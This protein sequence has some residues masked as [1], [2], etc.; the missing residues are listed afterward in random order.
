[1]KRNSKSLL[2][3]FFA[4]FTTFKSFGQLY[5]QG[6]TVNSNGNGQPN[7]GISIM[8]P[9]EKLHLDGNIKLEGSTNNRSI[10]LSP[11][12]GSGTRP[13]LSILG[14]NNG[15]N[16][17]GGPVNVAGGTGNYGTGGPLNLSGGNSSNYVGGNVNILGGNGVNGS[18]NV[19]I[20]GGT[21]TGSPTTGGYVQ[22]TTSNNASVP[23][24]D[25]SIQTGYNIATGA[26]YGTTFISGS[27]GN[28]TIGNFLSTNSISMFAGSAAQYI[29][30]TGI[31]INK[32]NPSYPLD[33]TGSMR[34]SGSYITS[35]MRY[36]KNIKSISNSLDIVKKLNGKS[37]DFDRIK[38]S[39][40]GF[41]SVGS[42]GF[43]AQDV[44]KILPNLVKEDN[45]GFLSI[46]YIGLMP[47]LVEAIKEQQK[48]IQS[49]SERLEA[50]ELKLKVNSELKSNQIQS[51][52]N[53]DN[54]DNILFQN[55]PNPFEK[56]TVISYKVPVNSRNIKIIIFDMQG[57]LI[58]QIENLTG[59]TGTITI[60]GNDL[61]AGMYIYSLLANDK[62][63]ASNKMILTK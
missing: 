47:F 4:V 51:V 8:Y 11:G 31:G 13:S 17:N 37:Y 30:N 60:E 55:S 56:H 24:A 39:K 41:D 26:N 57:T 59:G 20:K 43:L 40:M 10:Y 62:E 48:T 32:S 16:G 7:V 1:M 35:D 38:F 46:N 2:I 58:K 5:T 50:L 9:D 28:T 27:G 25:I 29:T 14:S 15:S 61:K 18:G 44:Q 49:Q 23:G 42:F 12:S 19:L 34:V 3:L 6:G 33:I 63:L 45:E 21:T 22:I 52:D 53:I 36:K 54:I